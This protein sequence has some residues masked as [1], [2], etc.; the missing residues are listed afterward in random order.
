[1]TRVSD[2]LTGPVGQNGEQRPPK[3]GVKFE[4][5]RSIPYGMG[6]LIMSSVDGHVSSVTAFETFRHLLCP[7]INSREMSGHVHR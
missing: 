6:R 5:Q 3:E 1:M 4:P 2:R 7:G